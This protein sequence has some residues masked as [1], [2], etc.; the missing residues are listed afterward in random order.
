MLKEISL[1]LSIAVLVLSIMIFVKVNKKAV[2]SGK[3]VKGYVS[4]GCEG[5]AAYRD[6]HDT[7]PNACTDQCN[8]GTGFNDCCEMICDKDANGAYINC[9]PTAGVHDYTTVCR[10]P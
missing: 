10:N 3:K 7:D 4:Q 5:L 9:D 2:P 1:L 6:G 8:T